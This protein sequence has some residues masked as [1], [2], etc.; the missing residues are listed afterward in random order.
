MKTKKNE[1]EQEFFLLEINKVS[2]LVIRGKLC[3]FLA[4]PPFDVAF[5]I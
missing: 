1:K 4:R 3:S 2:T 5:C